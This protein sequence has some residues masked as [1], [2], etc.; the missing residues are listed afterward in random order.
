MGNVGYTNV[1]NQMERLF[2]SIHQSYKRS[3]SGVKMVRVYD[4]PFN[5]ATVVEATYC[6]ESMEPR[7]MEY[8]DKTAEL[9]LFEKKPTDSKISQSSVFQLMDVTGC[10]VEVDYINR[11]GNRETLLLSNSEHDMVHLPISSTPLLFFC[12]TIISVVFTFDEQAASDETNR[13][14]TT[15]ARR[16]HIEFE[17]GNVRGILSTVSAALTRDRVCGFFHRAIEEDMSLGFGRVHTYSFT[18]HFN[19]RSWCPYTLSGDFIIPGLPVED[20][21]EQGEEEGP[22]EESEEI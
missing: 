3:L 12:P 20:K 1:V 18:Y 14:L 9:A 5:I 17:K 21:S 6:L 10:V 15:R 4:H 16:Y 19:N 2:L 13:D 7:E 22:A 8:K 11:M